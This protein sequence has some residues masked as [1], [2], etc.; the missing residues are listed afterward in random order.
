MPDPRIW[1]IG[2][3][4]I[5]SVEVGAVSLLILAANPYRADAD[6]TNDST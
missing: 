1:P 4:E 6:I 3:S 5:S 2:R